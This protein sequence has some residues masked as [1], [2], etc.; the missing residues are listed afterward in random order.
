M[1]MDE[2]TTLLASAI[3]APSSHNTQ[4]W[5][6]T[7]LDDAIQVH[8]DYTRALPVVDADHHA[9]WISLGCAVENIVIAA[10]Q[11]H[12]KAEVNVHAEGEGGEFIHVKFAPT[13]AI[14]PD[15][16]YECIEKRQS[17]RNVYT[18]Q[19]VSVQDLAVL[20]KSGEFSGVS[21]RFFDQDEFSLLEPFIMEGSDRQFGNER[22]IDELVRWMRFSHTEAER[23]RD[24]LWTSALGFPN[25]GAFVGR[26]IL[27]HVVTAK[28]EARRWKKLIRSSSGCILFVAETNDIVHWVNVGRAFQRFGLTAT[29][30]R[31]SHA[32]VNMPCEEV[33]VREQMADS[34]NF[35]GK[36]P[37]LLVRF[38]YSSSMP[39][40]LRRPLEE[41][42]YGDH[43]QS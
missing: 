21:T 12:K 37:L 31:I 40:S 20:S 22:F 27:K 7:V 17:T 24:G 36:H 8:P 1:S 9:L 38:G 11:Y 14:A 33:S 28:S 35:H 34:L 26:I 29:K 18:G 23:T 43:H 41:V 42:V 30:L 32:H 3:K 25:V 5:K 39:Y 16:L 19:K 13:S 6:F 15:D 4:P 2:V 10:T